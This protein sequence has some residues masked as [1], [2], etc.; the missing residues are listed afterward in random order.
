L[1]KISETSAV[2]NPAGHDVSVTS[3]TS[4]PPP[5]V[6]RRLTGTEALLWNLEQNPNLAST[7]ASIVILNGSPDPDRV[8]MTAA[9]A[10]CAIPGL[11]ERIFEPPVPLGT[12]QWGLDRNFDLDAHLRFLRLATPASRAGLFELA[13]QIISD[14][15]DRTRPLWSWTIVSGLPRGRAA[16]ISKFHHSI[17]DGQGALKLAEHMLEFEADAS[18]P[19]PIDLVD[20]LRQLEEVTDQHQPARSSGLRSGAERFLALLGQAAGSVDP[21]KVAAAGQEAAAAARSLAAQVAAG[22]VSTIWTDRSR[23]RRSRFISL[24]LTHLK[25]AAAE[26]DRSIN[27]LFVTACAR[28]TVKYHET[29]GAELPTVSATVVISTRRDGDPVAHN[30]VVPTAISLPGNDAAVEQQ[31]D[32][33]RDQVKARRGQLSGSQEIL[34]SLTGLAAMLPGPLASAAALEQSAKVDISTSNL[35]GPSVPL[36]FGGCA[37]TEWFPL[38]PVAGTASNITMLSYNDTA[39]IGLH[40]DPV[41]ITDPDTFARCVAEGLSDLGVH[42]P[43]TR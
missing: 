32:A 1:A 33:V 5:A 40:I 19:A 2:W 42:R 15:F 11:R 30:A 36:W 31:L 18:A 39:Y 41:A 7:M 35:P 24:P 14:P 28:G 10:V 37:I 9:K 20:F 26:H 3:A 6:P 16:L 27:D 21:V 29:L 23:N 12:P 25:A 17:A 22:S 38:G 4:V 8:R 34:G 43:K 13:T